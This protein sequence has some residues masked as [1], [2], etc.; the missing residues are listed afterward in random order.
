MAHILDY[1]NQQLNA[2]AIYGSKSVV[3]LQIGKFYDIFEY[4]PQLCESQQDRT[5]KTG[6][7]WDVK[8]GHALTLT[9]IIDCEVVL[10]EG[11]YSILNPNYIGFPNVAYEKKK[12]LL[13]NAGYTIVR[14]DQRKDDNVVTRFIAEIVN[15]KLVPEAEAVSNHIVSLYIECQN[16]NLKPENITI[17]AGLAYFETI[18]GKNGA[19]EF[20]SLVGDEVHALQEIYRILSSLK[21][22]EIMIYVEDLPSQLVVENSPY[23]KYLTA[24]LN[25][26][27]ATFKLNSLSKET[28]SI[29]YHVEAL[30]RLFLSENRNIIQHLGLNR[31][32][33]AR[34]A[35]IILMNYCYRYDPN[36]ILNLSKPDIDIVSDRLI[37]TH[38]A[39]DQLDLFGKGKCLLNIMDNCLTVSGSR[40]L[41]SLMVSPMKNIFDIVDH[42]DMIDEMTSLYKQII[43][44]LKSFPDID[45]FHRLLKIQRL[46]PHDYVKL[47]NAYLK[48]VDIYSIIFTA[49]CPQLQNN[50]MSSPYTENFD[51]FLT[52][53]GNLFDNT[54]LKH[55]DGKEFTTSVVKTGVI[56]EVDTHYN[57]LLQHEKDLQIIVDHL[58]SLG[59]TKSTKPISFKNK[60]KRDKLGSC[61]LYTTPARAN[62]LIRLDKNLS[63]VHHSTS[64][65][66]ITSPAIGKLTLQI[67][68]EREWLVDRFNQIYKSAVIEM[69][70]Y[71]F[72]Q[73]L[74]NTVA[75]IDVIHNYAKISDWYNYHRPGVISASSQVS[76]TGLRHPI[77]E[78]IIDGKYQVN[79]VSFGSPN[80]TDRSL[81]LCL[82]GPNATGK[83]S[84]TKGV[85]LNIIMA[86]MGC[87]VAAESMT[88]TPYGQ[89]LTRLNKN[90]NML[91]NQ[92]T[93]EVEMEELRTILRHADSESLVVSDELCSS[94]EHRSALALTISTIKHLISVNSSFILA[95]HQ[96]DM[97]EHLE[98]IDSSLLKIAH[99]SIS[100]DDGLLIYDR[101]LQP[102]SGPKNYGVMVAQSLGL[103]ET[104]IREAYRFIHDVELI[105]PITSKYNSA[106]YVD[107]CVLCNS[108]ENVQTHHIEEQHLADAKGFIGN[109][110]KN[111]KDNLIS[112]CMVCHSRIHREKKD[113]V[114]KQG[115]NGRIVKI[116]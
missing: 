24:Q 35:Y 72:Y 88:Y 109:M 73:H 77:I 31:L 92:S 10:E 20:Y 42:Y 51:L 43:P 54:G 112:L 16:N 104:F 36:I 32:N 106:V 115:I 71:D 27:N 67:D 9:K 114:V 101:L 26:N 85:V 19:A 17:T 102:G 69:A 57:Q 95:T 108:I 79:D 33:Y 97:V 2:E 50:L 38:N 82:Y 75:L 110:H 93:F 22:R 103:P 45:K 34:N 116:K 94:T 58:N 7:V 53:Y 48:I 11:P 98:N 81:G 8:I 28:K 25:L 46:N 62:A 83:T 30:N 100:V 52:K 23:I 5:D 111:V 59:N 63:I 99:L 65:K 44:L 55:F 14:M 84:L 39:G 89:I 107:K 90:D 40:K 56:P 13:L 66:S 113:M 47:Y 18:T 87:F 3:L 70:D 41:K 86:Q 76:I 74:A 91:A 37:L 49:D 1:F 21:Y 68:E 4:N 64:K 12:R 78:Q 15:P 60:K 29:D 105:K 61:L 80:G 96:H 6:K